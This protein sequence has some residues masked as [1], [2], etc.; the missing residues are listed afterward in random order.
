MMRSPLKHHI[1]P[2]MFSGVRKVG[3]GG[4][5]KFSVIEK[6]K[7]ITGKDWA[8]RVQEGAFVTGST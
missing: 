3:V 4:I 5:I 6:E 8:V 7:E 1:S 2:C